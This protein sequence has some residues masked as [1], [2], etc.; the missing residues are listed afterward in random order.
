MQEGVFRKHLLLD[1]N[2]NLRQD[3]HTPHFELIYGNKKERTKGGR[4]YEYFNTFEELILW[5][6]NN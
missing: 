5:Y 3:S 1:D 2:V 4:R 6:F